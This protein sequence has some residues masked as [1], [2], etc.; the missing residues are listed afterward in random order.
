MSNI[1]NKLD[2]WIKKMDKAEETGDM[3][4][5]NKAVVIIQHLEYLQ[6]MNMD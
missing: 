6:E 2:L 1:E 3:D 4:T 5:Y